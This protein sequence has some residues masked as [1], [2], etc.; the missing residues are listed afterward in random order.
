LPGLKRAL[1]KKM[2]LSVRLA[3]QELESILE[4]LEF[5]GYGAYVQVDLSTLRSQTYYTGMVFEAYTSGIGYPIGGGGRYDQLLQHFGVNYAATGFALGVE[6]IL[7]GLGNLPSKGKGYLLAGKASAGMLKEAAKLRQ[8][9]KPVVVLLET[10]TH[11]EA[12]AKSREQE[13][14]LIWFDGGSHYG[15]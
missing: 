11:G 8:E 12:L 13:L 5:Y 1:E 10:M 3:L 15:E 4:Y 9:G 7:I 2:P 6:R 14:E